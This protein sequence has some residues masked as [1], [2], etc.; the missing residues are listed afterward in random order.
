MKTTPHQPVTP[1]ERHLGSGVEH[2]RQTM[3]QKR[4]GGTV[5]KRRG[6][7]PVTGDTVLRH[8]D[9]VERI[10]L[11]RQVIGSEPDQ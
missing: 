8:I 4:S 2:E 7:V 3:N 9:V 1:A 11:V 6:Q 5:G 10:P